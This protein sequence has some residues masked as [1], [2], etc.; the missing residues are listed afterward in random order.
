VASEE[1][2]S[3][4]KAIEELEAIIREIEAE[5]VDVDILADKVKRATHLIKFCKNRLRSTEEEVKKVLS[6]IEEKEETP[7]EGDPS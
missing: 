6:D 3:Y 1:T 2:L 4:V 7:T 5:N